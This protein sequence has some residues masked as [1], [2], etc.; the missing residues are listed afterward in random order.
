[1]ILFT[2]ATAILIVQFFGVLIVLVA[3]TRQ[4]KE[5]NSS[6]RAEVDG[7]RC[8]PF[9]DLTHVLLTFSFF[10]SS[11]RPVPEI[12]WY[13]NGSRIKDF[14]DSFLFE[15]YNRTLRLGSLHPKIHNGVYSCEAVGKLRKIATFQIKV[16]GERPLHNI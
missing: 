2:Q 10:L 11:S 12:F 1:M 8:F 13:Q 5:M 9:Q 4:T 15:N 6:V 7:N 16:L 14:G 3:L